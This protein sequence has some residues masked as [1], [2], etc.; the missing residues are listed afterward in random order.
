MDDDVM[1]V[2]KAIDDL[3]RSNGS[4][5]TN[6]QQLTAA[7]GMSDDDIGLTLA[8]ALTA[9]LV[10]V[11]GPNQDYTLTGPGFTAIGR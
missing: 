8:K 3:E 9:G 6:R 7:S 10:K 5:S 11:V 4:Q 2:L 1:T